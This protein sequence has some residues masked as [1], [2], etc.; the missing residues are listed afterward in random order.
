MDESL[1]NELHE[2]KSLMP[3]CIEC[4]CESCRLNPRGVCLAPLLTGKAPNWDDHDGCHD[5]VYLKEQA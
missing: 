2:V 4:D 5:Y 1:K 3:L